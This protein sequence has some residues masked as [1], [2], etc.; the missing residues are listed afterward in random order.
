M[1]SVLG[2]LEPFSEPLPGSKCLVAWF[3][4]WAEYEKHASIAEQNEKLRV[5]IARAHTRTRTQT[6]AYANDRRD[7]SFDRGRS[8]DDNFYPVAISLV[9]TVVAGHATIANCQFILQ[10]IVVQRDITKSGPQGFC[11]LGRPRRN[12]LNFIQLQ[13]FNIFCIG[14]I[15]TPSF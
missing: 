15:C 9:I 8:T 13:Y 11:L 7:I 5:L 1:C 3:C 4:N 10:L 12:T 2:W 14:K 6:G